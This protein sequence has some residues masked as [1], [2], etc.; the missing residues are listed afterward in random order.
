MKFLLEKHFAGTKYRGIQKEFKIDDSLSTS[1]QLY[2]NS[3]DFIYSVK[4]KKLNSR[5]NTTLKQK[6]LVKLA[7]TIYFDLF[8]DSVL[9]DIAY[10]SDNIVY[11][12]VSIS[13]TPVPVKGYNA[14]SKRMHD[15]LKAQIADNKLSLDSIKSIN[16]AKFIVRADGTVLAS[17]RGYLTMALTEF[18]KEEKRW[19]PGMHS[20]PP[21]N[22]K[23]SFIIMLS[24][25]FGED[26]VWS[27]DY[28]K[29]Q[30]HFENLSFLSDGQKEVFYHHEFPTKGKETVISAIYDP[31]LK[32]YRLPYIH[33][34]NNENAT[35]L[36]TLINKNSGKHYGED[37]YNFK[38]KYFYTY[39][40]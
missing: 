35:K 24:Y 26:K 38:R 3:T 36:I 9:V 21:A 1:Y 31:M 28:G 18:L 27:S 30:M 17:K 33:V 23:V 29:Q 13:S 14:F 12:F 37:I 6:G 20:G 19:N 25:L 15:F 39:A 11:E 34:D 2:G 7:G 22:S 32:K 4:L 8:L 5:L 10:R 16:S 40:F